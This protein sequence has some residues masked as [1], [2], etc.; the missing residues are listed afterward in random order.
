MHLKVLISRN[1][2]KLL[3]RFIHINDFGFNAK[4]LKCAFKVVAI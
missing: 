4:D 2:F 3:L 1:A